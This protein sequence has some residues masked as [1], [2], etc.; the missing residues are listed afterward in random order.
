MISARAWKW[1]TGSSRACGERPGDLAGPDKPSA[2]PV[3]REGPVM[4]F[5]LGASYVLFPTVQVTG[6]VGYHA[7]G[8]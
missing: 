4:V 2:E 3:P 6:L 8:F 5:S 1:S 7:A